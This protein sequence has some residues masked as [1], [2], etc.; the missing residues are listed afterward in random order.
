MESERLKLVP[1]SLKYA[2]AMYQVIDESR[3]ELSQFLPWVSDEFTK[4]RLK[5][6][7][8]E[9]AHNFAN[10]TDE[11]WF[12]I[13]EKETGLFVGAIGFIVRD[14]SVPYFEIGYWLKTSKTGLGY[15]S[16]AI[17]LVE[18]YAFINKEAQRVEI[19][20]AG[21]NFRSQ[22][23]ANRCGYKLEAHLANARRLPSGE[24]DSTV[25]YAKMYLQQ[26]VQE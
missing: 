18:R 21:S 12:N 15:V 8:K 24:L 7:I 6:N 23:V 16:E 2:D 13:I 22:S 3:L 1:P 17:G 9:A 25:V 26:S 11:F 5:Q 19:K 4:S 20:M 10:F 14:K